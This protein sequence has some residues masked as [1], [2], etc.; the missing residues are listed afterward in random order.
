MGEFISSKAVLCLG[1]GVLAFCMYIS[2]TLIG[3]LNSLEEKS[4]TPLFPRSQ[5]MVINAELC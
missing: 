4:N 2:I 3:T 1:F 5:R